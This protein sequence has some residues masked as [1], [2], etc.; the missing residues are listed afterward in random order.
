[1]AS[2]AF[3]LDDV[4]AVIQAGLSHIPARSRFFEAI[5]NVVKWYREGLDWQAIGHEINH[6]YGHY[7]MEGTINNA[8]CVAAALLCGCGDAKAPPAVSFE[9]TIT[10]A[11][12]LGFDTDCNGA[13]A[14][15]VAGLMIGGSMLPEKWTNPLQDTLRTCVSGFGQVRISDIARRGYELSRIGVPRVQKV[16]N[17]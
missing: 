9:R 6:H 16:S 7:G 3:V 4:Q 1:M 12:Q 17:Y 13:T 2:A 8:C 11:V 10:T 15:S 5:N 14:G